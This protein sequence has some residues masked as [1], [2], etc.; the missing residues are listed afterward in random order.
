MALWRCIHPLRACFLVTALGVAW[1][2]FESEAHADPRV[3]GGFSINGGY[4]GAA[5]NTDK[6]SGG[7]IS[8][9]GRIGVQIGEVFSLY[10]QNTPVGW[11]QFQ[12]G[13]HV[14]GSDYNS[15]LAD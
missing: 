3:R 1:A 4:F 13:A 9:A 7:A 10:Y 15:V 12:G 8:L 11:I 6:F 14:G 5:S 2:G